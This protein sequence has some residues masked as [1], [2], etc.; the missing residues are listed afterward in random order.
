MKRLLRPSVLVPATFFAGLA[1][2]AAGVGMVNTAAGVIS[3]GA[4]AVA[5][6]V[7]YERNA[8]RRDD[9]E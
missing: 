9:D 7:T 8:R 5:A 6:A 1:A 2:I 4:I 3:A